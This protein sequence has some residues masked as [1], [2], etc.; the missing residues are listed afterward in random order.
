LS[1][2]LVVTGTGTDVGKTHV[3]TALLRAWGTTRKVFGYKPVESGVGAAGLG[4]D[5]RRLAEASTFH[6]KR[7]LFGYA[8]GPPISPHLAARRDGVVVDIAK[9]ATQV[10]ELRSEVE[11]L[12]VELAGGLF[13]P[14]SRETVNLDLA[15]ALQATAI[16]LV[17][18]DRIGVLHDVGATV[19][20][21]NASGLS[22]QGIA[23]CAPAV[24][25]ASTGTNVTELM[26]ITGL[27]VLASFPR[28]P[29]DAPVSSV[30][31][32]ALLEGLALGGD[33]GEGSLDTKAS[34]SL[35][36]RRG[37]LGQR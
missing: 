32:R 35:A 12:V 11:G 30:A 25:D 7:S 36:N 26:D 20:A 31:A 33:P 3:A 13:S 37:S 21:A 2:L 6:V 29:L 34:G 22:L 17:A 16:L 24:S 28:A 18:P 15:K 9:I 5:A 23:L 10:A 1:P 8:F 19:R 4:D 14:L 27:C